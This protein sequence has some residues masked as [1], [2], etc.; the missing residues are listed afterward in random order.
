M[1]R[2]LPPPAAGKQWLVYRPGPA[3]KNI[4]IDTADPEA[5][6]A[7]WNGMAVKN[8]QVPPLRGACTPSP[9][10]APL[11]ALLM[12]APP[13]KATI[14]PP[15]P[16]SYSPRYR[17]YPHGQPRHHYAAGAG[18]RHGGRA[19]RGRHAHRH[20]AYQRREQRR[21][22][23]QWPLPRRRQKILRTT[24]GRVLPASGWSRR[25]GAASDYIIWAL[26]ASRRSRRI[27]CRQRKYQRDD[28]YMGVLHRKTTAYPPARY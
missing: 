5:W 22:G 2:A 6:A 1:L 8:E 19:D 13:S 14:P 4:F 25:G 28:L 24:G 20:T 18:S 21:H 12:R 11:A 16:A 9:S 27:L 3:A 15:A 26:D 7:R 17:T 10:R 23:G